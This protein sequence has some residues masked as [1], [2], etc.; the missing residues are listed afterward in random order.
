MSGKK[1]RRGKA[2]AH[3]SEDNR[4]KVCLEVQR[5]SD[6]GK[7][8]STSFANSSNGHLF[9]QYDKILCYDMQN[10]N[11]HMGEDDE[12]ISKITDVVVVKK[13]YTRKR[14]KK[15]IWKLKKLHEEVQMEVPSQSQKA[16][17]TQKVM[18][19]IFENII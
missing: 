19:L 11:R 7:N 12:E 16:K 5:K 15:R 10:F 9:K 18:N 13:L 17:N 3:I 6:F 8:S 2:V 14:N 4:N 1:K